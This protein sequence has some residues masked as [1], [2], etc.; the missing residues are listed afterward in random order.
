MKDDSTTFATF[1]MPVN[2]DIFTEL[3]RVQQGP[4]TRK[5][6]I[7]GGVL[8]SIMTLFAI[9]DFLAEPGIKS[10]GIAVIFATLVALSVAMVRD[11]AYMLHFRGK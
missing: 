1:E 11:P 2:I 7:L 5:L 10:L 3:F 4:Y 6:G 9:L 8:C